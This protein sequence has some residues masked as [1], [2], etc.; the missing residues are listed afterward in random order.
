MAAILAHRKSIKM[1]SQD[2][3]ATRQGSLAPP[4]GSVELK[5]DLM[6]VR[7]VQARI[8]RYQIGVHGRGCQ[9]H[10]KS[11]ALWPRVLP[12]VGLGRRQSIEMV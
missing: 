1:T 6:R 11:K 12:N 5:C 9:G 4:G 7:L 3:F 2:P 8:G 10:S